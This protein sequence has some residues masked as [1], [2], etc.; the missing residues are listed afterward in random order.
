MFSALIPV[1][2]YQGLDFND[3]SVGD[4]LFSGGNGQHTHC[5]TERA[6]GR[7]PKIYPVKSFN[8]KKNIVILRH[9]LNA[10]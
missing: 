8:V 2:I 1:F 9:D 3:I 7:Q 5:I 4:G 10:D 6:Q